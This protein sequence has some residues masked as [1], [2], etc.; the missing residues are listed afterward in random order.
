MIC[1]QISELLGFTCQPLSDDG[2][3]ALIDT[4]FSF[5]D[6]VS[7]NVFVEKTGSQIRFFDDGEILLHFLGRGVRLDGA[8]QTRF[9]KTIADSHGVSFTEQGELEIWTSSLTA[10]VAFASFTSTL[11]GLIEWEKGQIGVAS[12]LSL[13][14]SEVALCLQAWKPVA[15]L[16][17]NPAYTGISGHVYKLDFD[18]DGQGVIAITPH[19]AAVSSAI[20]KL[21]DILSAPNNQKMKIMVVIDDRQDPVGAAKESLILDAVSNVMSMTALE[22]QAGLSNSLS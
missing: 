19:H 10:S 6:G 4:P 5:E 16:T 1:S 15:K 14:I 12:D 18:F 2:S 8:R 9:I 20:K 21:V 17:N 11:V 22:K 7:V 3:V 13:L